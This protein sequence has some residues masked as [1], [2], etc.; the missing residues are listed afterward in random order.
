VIA[1]INGLDQSISL[2]RKLANTW[3]K[4]GET[5]MRSLLA[6][7]QNELADAKLLMADLKERVAAHVSMARPQ[8]SNPLSVRS[9]RGSPASARGDRVR[10]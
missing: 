2:V 7:L 1:V 3:N 10:G 5:D 9:T 4:I 6:D 8:N